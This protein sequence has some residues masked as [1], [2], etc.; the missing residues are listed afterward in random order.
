MGWKTGDKSVP[1]PT[2]V[3]SEGLVKVISG[4]VTAAQ[5]YALWLVDNS[6]RKD[7]AMFF[8][9]TFDFAPEW[10]FSLKAPWNSGL[11]QGLALGLFSLLYKHTGQDEYRYF[12]DMIYRSY[13]IPLEK[14]GF[15]RFEE[16]GPF[17]EEYPTKTPTRVLNGAAVAMLA[18]HDYATIFN[19]K[20]AERMFESSVHRFDELLGK[21]EIKEPLSGITTSSYSLAPVR[22]EILGRF[23]GE[24]NIFVTKMKLIGIKKDSEKDISSVQIGVPS[25]DDV[26][27]EFYVWPDKKLMNWGDSG[28]IDGVP[29]RETNER[30]G[31]YDHAPFEFSMPQAETF[32]A[33]AVEVTW[34]PLKNWNNKPVNVQLY[35]GNEWWPLG[36]IIPKGEKGLQKQKFSFGSEFYESWNKSTNTDLKMDEKYLDDNQILVSLIG[37]ISGSETCN[38]Y[39]Q[40][41]QQSI[42]L[43]PARWL[44]RYPPAF[45]FSKVGNRF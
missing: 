15:T 4:D 31:E 22:P 30:K 21:Y 16:D 41:W 29:G 7:G 6:T 39:A 28:I 42:D 26:M 12:A 20:E 14:G 18:L 45:L 25:D 35:D 38:Y 2:K 32:D 5:K 11:T 34:L 27:R 36:T 23:V 17:F 33:Y 19:N 40:R 13:Q 24:G 9:F 37:Q 1:S 8:P 3:A 44:N 10:P 43:V